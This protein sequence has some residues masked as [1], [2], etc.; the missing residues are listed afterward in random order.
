MIRHEASHRHAMG[1]ARDRGAVGAARA[2]LL[3]AAADAASAGAGARDTVVSRCGA[4]SRAK[5]ALEC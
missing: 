2:E 1:F 4:R 5:P 3:V